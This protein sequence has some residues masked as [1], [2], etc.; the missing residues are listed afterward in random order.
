VRRSSAFLIDF[1][2]SS[3]FTTLIEFAPAMCINNCI[4]NKPLLV[5]ALLLCLMT[6]G[7]A[8]SSADYAAPVVWERYKISD[9]NISLLLP[10]MPTVIR[11][12]AVCSG[13][14][15][16]SFFTYAENSVYELEIT[17]KYS[18]QVPRFVC[19]EYKKTFGPGSLTDR[20]DE[21]RAGAEKPAESKVRQNGREVYRFASA[22]R[23]R[24]IYPDL[25]KDRWIELGVSYR[26][27]AKAD[28]ERFASSLKFSDS[29][30][31]DIGKG[32]DRTLG[33]LTKSSTSVPPSATNRATG[34][35]AGPGSG[36]GPAKVYD[37]SKAGE[38]SGSQLLADPY[39][40]VSQPKAAYTDEAR[41]SN[42]EGPVRLK[43]T[44]LSNGG[45]G[46][47]SVVKGLPLGLTE[48]AIAAAK[49]I[50]FL[51]KRVNGVPVSVVVTREY[52]FTIY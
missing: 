48:H 27:D 16:E 33:D 18:K 43:I 50:V 7:S 17:S 8:Q 20:L 42:L 28:L 52:T 5:T 34:T 29:N 40:V 9:E 25:Q 31:K 12:Y 23:T 47:I 1:V 21:L 22:G 49:K 45:V 44:L 36:A 10:K 39:L 4:M 11:S 35:S 32:S 38:L 26:Q 41:A 19:P 14:Q 24:W 37:A 30:G 15:T 3:G 46:S 6:P 51:P 13:T 2:F